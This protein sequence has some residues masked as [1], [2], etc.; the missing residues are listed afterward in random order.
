[1][2]IFLLITLGRLE[3][4]LLAPS[5]ATPCASSGYSSIST[6]SFYDVPSKFG[7]L[8]QSEQAQPRSDVV[9][10]RRVEIFLRV[11]AAVPWMRKDDQLLPRRLPDRSGPP[12]RH[13]HR[14]AVPPAAAAICAARSCA[15]SNICPVALRFSMLSMFMLNAFIP[16]TF[17]YASCAV[18]SPPGMPPI[19]ESLRQKPSLL[20]AICI[21]RPTNLVVGPSRCSSRRCQNGQR[22]WT[23]RVTAAAVPQAS[24]TT[25]ASRRGTWD[26]PMC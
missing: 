25:A 4:F 14:S 12:R 21:Q 2:P 5:A 20:A 16:A 13:R 17:S 10:H 8:V 22:C 26:T 23:A 1:M 3:H 6:I 15:S 7:V 18:F 11:R 19:P 9:Q 24:T